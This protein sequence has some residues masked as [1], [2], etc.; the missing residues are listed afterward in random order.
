MAEK[1]D[2]TQAELLQPGGGGCEGIE[3]TWGW[4][5]KHGIRGTVEK[6][7]RRVMWEGAYL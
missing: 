6:K 3:K 2:R 7:A 1:E 5:M 4:G